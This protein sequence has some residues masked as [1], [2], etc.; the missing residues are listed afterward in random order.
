[1][2]EQQFIKSK[3][4]H[5]LLLAKSKSTKETFVDQITIKTS[6]GVVQPEPSDD[7]VLYVGGLDVGHQDLLIKTSGKE[8]KEMIKFAQKK[9]RMDILRRMKQ[10][11][12]RIKSTNL[13]EIYTR[14]QE[15]IIF[16]SEIV[17]YYCF[18]FRVFDIPVP[19]L[20]DLPNQTTQ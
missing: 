14:K 3:E 15:F 12:E 9:K 2:T 18:R 1:M 6:D 10:L 11:D 7:Q 8:I 5:Y 19:I 17:D 13:E 20:Y 4:T 16:C